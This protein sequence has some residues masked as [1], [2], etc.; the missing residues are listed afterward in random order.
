VCC[1][2]SPSRTSSRSGTSRRSPWSPKGFELSDTRVEAEWLHVYPRGRRQVWFDRDAADAEPLRFPGDHLKGERATIA[3]MTRPNALFLSTAAACNHPDLSVLYRW[4]QGNLWLVSP[5]G[6]RDDRERFTGSRM[7][8][9]DRARIL[10]LLRVA[11]LGI[12]DVEVV[13]RDPDPPEVRLVRMS[14][15]HRVPF[16][17]DNESYGTRNWF[18]LLGPLLLTLRD[19]AVLLVD[20]LDNSLHPTLVAEFV[21]LFQDPEANPKNAQLIFTSHDTVPLGSATGAGRSA[22]SRCG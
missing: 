21:R 12:D 10:E 17:L 6:G 19:G 11:D 5:E 7:L 8:T 22:A 13:P 14:R 1:S 16:D 15:G 9:K 4:F 3:R 2:G 18:A 20:E